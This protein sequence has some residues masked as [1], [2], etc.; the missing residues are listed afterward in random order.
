MW[1]KEIALDFYSRFNQTNPLS[2]D[3]PMRYR[4]EVLEPGGSLPANDLVRN[5][6]GRPQNMQA[7]SRWIGAE[8][9]AH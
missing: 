3:V 5:F 9:A 4:R 2:G 1:D 8:F 7:F 6:L